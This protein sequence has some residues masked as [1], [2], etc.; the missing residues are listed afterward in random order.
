MFVSFF[1]FWF[2]VQ[3]KINGEYAED[4]EA[5]YCPPNLTFLKAKQM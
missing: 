2:G 1:M 4:T 5:R 3:N